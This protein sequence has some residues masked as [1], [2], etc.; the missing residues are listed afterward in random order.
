MPIAKCQRHY[1]AHSDIA[2]ESALQL[3]PHDTP[4]HPH[5]HEMWIGIWNKQRAAPIPKHFDSLSHFPRASITITIIPFEHT[6]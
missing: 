1:I 2:K 5:T 3:K 4:T 6:L